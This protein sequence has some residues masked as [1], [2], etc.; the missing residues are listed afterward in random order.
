MDAIAFFPPAEVKNAFNAVK[1][2]APQHPKVLEYIT[3]KEKTWVG[4]LTS[5]IEPG[6]LVIRTKWNKPM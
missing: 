3:Y 5:E 1:A 6:T 4:Y 2:R